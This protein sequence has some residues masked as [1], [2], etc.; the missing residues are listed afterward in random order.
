[1]KISHLLL[2]CWWHA[3][4][5]CRGRGD[6]LKFRDVSRSLNLLDVDGYVAAVADVTNDRLVDLI[7]VEDKGQRAT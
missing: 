2:L 6:E 5:L 4:S 1:M 7:V 3:V